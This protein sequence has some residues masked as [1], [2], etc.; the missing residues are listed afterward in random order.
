VPKFPKKLPKNAPDESQYKGTVEIKG[1]L[2]KVDLEVYKTKIKSWLTL[3][4]LK[5]I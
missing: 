4:S 3:K 5:K 1:S 2:Y